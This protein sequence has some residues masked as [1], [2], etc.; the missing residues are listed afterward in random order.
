MY[1]ETSAP[2]MY[3]QKARLISPTQNFIDGKCLYFWYHAYGT[4]V[5]SLKIYSEIQT[6]QTIKPRN[7]LWTID[8]NQGDTWF[9]ARVPTDYSDN[10]KIIFEGIVGKSYKGDVVSR[11]FLLNK[12]DLIDS[13]F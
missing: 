9:I 13:I 1:I 5:A 11:F 7:L 6:N 10:F 2:Q 8:R 4:D 12:N 3:N